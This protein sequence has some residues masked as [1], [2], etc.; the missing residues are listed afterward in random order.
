MMSS[1]TKPQIQLLVNS[2]LL[3]NDPEL[4]PIRAVS[5]TG[6]A[7]TPVSGTVGVDVEY[8]D[9]QTYWSPQALA[10]DLSGEPTV[11]YITDSVLQNITAGTPQRCPVVS[12][13]Q[14]YALLGIYMDGVTA[15]AFTALSNVARLELDMDSVGFNVFRAYGSGTNI[16]V[17][18]AYEELREVYQQDFDEGVFPWILGATTGINNPDNRDG[19]QVLNMAP[20][21]WTDVRHGVQFTTTGVVY[22][23]RIA[24]YLLSLNPAGLKLQNV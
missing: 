17:Y 4:N 8:M 18:D 19:V 6:H 20:G 22:P 24:T 1:A 15:G 14:H 12:L 21:G 3:G 23:A 2:T 16:D 7:I 5:G 11:Q 10:M 13:F 9:G